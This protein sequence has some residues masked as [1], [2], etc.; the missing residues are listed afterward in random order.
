LI[1]AQY[2]NVISNHNITFLKRGFNDTYLLSA[3]EINA[4][5]YIFR[6]YKHKW[7]S[8]ETIK[9]E[10]HLLNYLNENKVSVSYPIQNIKGECIQQINAPEG[11]RYAVLFSFA[12]GRTIKKLSLEQAYLLGTQTGT[13]HHLL[14]NKNFGITA[15]NYSIEKQF[16]TAL[17]T[18]KP[19][20]IEYPEQYIYLQDLYQEFLLVF[21]ED[22]KKQ[23]Q[24]GIC[25][26][27][28]QSENFHI[29]DD[30]RFTFFDFDFFGTGHLA[31]DIGVFKWY[32]Q[33]NKTPEIMSAFLKG[34]QTQQPLSETELKL[35][36]YF[37]TIRAL[38]QMALY[39]NLS[40]GKQLPIWPA[41]QVAAFVK[42]INKW[43]QAHKLVH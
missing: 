36:P 37:S 17:N 43:Q 6:V 11:I 13:I 27:D 24:S 30:N 26:G 28:L 20:L 38:F 21:N 34:Y 15:H 33:Q 40:N 10:L 39:C 7:R 41:E 12:E 22:T 5:K 29:T 35:I 2:A 25:H 31:Y 9:T 19:I 32:D 18:L 16:E 1:K 3:K 42:K 4:T 14:Q 23:L 8:L